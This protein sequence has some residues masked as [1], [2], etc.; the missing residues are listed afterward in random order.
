[1]YDSTGFLECISLN[2]PTICYLPGGFQMLENN[3]KKTYYKLLK[4]K[5]IFVDPTKLSRHL[6]FLNLNT[7]LKE[8]WED[9][10]LQKEL[11]IFKN[12]FCIMSNNNSHKK[13][14]KIILSKIN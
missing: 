1:M 2:Y 11:E 6:N 3:V 10:S 9:K 5:I 7:H 4:H 14:K 13:I 12:N 8:W